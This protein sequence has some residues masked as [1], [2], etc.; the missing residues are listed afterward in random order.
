MARPTTKN[1]NPQTAVLVYLP[2]QL[3]AKLD[4]RVKE[5][6]SETGLNA[7]R[8]AVVRKLLALAFALSEQ[9]KK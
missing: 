9:H 2:P 6:A 5:E 8:T 4:A 1:A 7:S 3:L